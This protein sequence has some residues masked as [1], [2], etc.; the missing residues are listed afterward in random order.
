MSKRDG[1]MG[2]ANATRS[3]E[4]DI[5]GTAN[6]QLASKDDKSC[7]ATIYARLGCAQPDLVAQQGR[8]IVTRGL[9]AYWS[10]NGEKDCLVERGLDIGVGRID[11]ND[12]R[13]REAIRKI[14]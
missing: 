9:G 14:I 10:T 5:L 6:K 13:G 4:H 1:K 8:L 12:A 3:E 2:F 11:R 7:P